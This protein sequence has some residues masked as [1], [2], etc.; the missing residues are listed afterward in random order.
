MLIYRADSGK[1]R[2]ENSANAIGA[3]V[4]TVKILQSFDQMASHGTRHIAAVKNV[5]T[6]M[7]ETNVR[8]RTPVYSKTIM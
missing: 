8:Q 4:T 1:I 7:F 2:G 5:P 6:L 3:A